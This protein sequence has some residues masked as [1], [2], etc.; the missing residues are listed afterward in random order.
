M[1]SCGLLNKKFKNCFSAAFLRFTIK[2]I[3][4]FFGI[5]NA[6]KLSSSI[7]FGNFEQ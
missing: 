1:P 6:S 2:E 5:L 4:D 7:V 3:F